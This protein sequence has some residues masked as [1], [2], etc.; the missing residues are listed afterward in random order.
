MVE[1]LVATDD[2]A[3]GLCQGAGEEA[4]TAVGQQAATLQDDPGHHR[5]LGVAADVGIGIAGI[6]AGG[7]LQGRLDDDLLTHLP[8]VLEIFAYLQDLAAHFVAD[9]HGVFRYIL[10]HT[11]VAGALLDGLVGG[12][13]DAVA[14]HTDEDLIGGDIRQL[15]LFQANVVCAVESER[16]CFHFLYLLSEFAL[17]FSCGSIILNLEKKVNSRHE[18]FQM[19]MLSLEIITNNQRGNQNVDQRT[20]YPNHL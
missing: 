15:E 1:A 16:F 17:T 3:Q 20:A 5:I 18:I 6:V 9:D 11:L 7:Q 2:A 19:I 8:A 10:R 12:G 4:L 13:A 14:D